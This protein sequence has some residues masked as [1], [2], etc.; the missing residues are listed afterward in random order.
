ME[1]EARPGPV[2]AT[3]A[4]LFA[5]LA[6]SV[7]SFTLL[8]VWY[9]STNPALPLLTKMAGVAKVFLLGMAF[10]IFWLIYAV[11][12]WRQKRWAVPLGWA[13]AA[14]VLLFGIKIPQSGSGLLCAAI[15]LGVSLS[16]AI[17]L[18]RRRARLS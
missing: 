3:F 15:A 9:T 6:L 1:E 16:P 14:F 13:Y 17:L 7:I 4:V 10:G 5:L 12:I 11:G 2:L 8:A 18:T